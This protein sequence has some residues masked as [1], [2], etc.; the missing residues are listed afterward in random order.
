MQ[1]HHYP[2]QNNECY[3]FFGV[4][5][6]LWSTGKKDIKGI[7]SLSSSVRKQYRKQ[8]KSHKCTLLSAKTEGHSGSTNEEIWSTSLT[9]RRGLFPGMLPRTRDNRAGSW[10]ISH[11][12]AENKM[13]RALQAKAAKMHSVVRSNMTHA[14][15]RHRRG[16]ARTQVHGREGDLRRCSGDAPGKVSR[17]HPRGV[18]N[19]KVYQHFLK[20]E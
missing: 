6:H 7:E 3:F 20:L 14:N 19:H 8:T 4:D 13:G 18:I 5:E 12:W 15:N 11:S 1:L 10:R 16:K 17:T 9:Q 2:Q